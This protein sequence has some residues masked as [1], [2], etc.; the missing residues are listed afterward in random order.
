MIDQYVR[1]LRRYDAIGLE[2][3]L[4]DGLIE[5]NRQLSRVLNEYG[6]EHSFE[7]Y[8]GDHTNRV[9]E[10]FAGWVLPFFSEHLQF[11]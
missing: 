11:D 1:N 8:E 5:A 7:T 6:I 3:G 2:V 4:Q 10:R 9:A